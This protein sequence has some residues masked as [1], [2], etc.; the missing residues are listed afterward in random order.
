MERKKF[1]DMCQESSLLKDGMFGIKKDVPDALKVK[2]MQG[3][4]AGNI[5]YYPCGYTLSFIQGKTTHTCILHDLE[6]NSVCNVDL[7][8]VEPIL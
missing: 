1:L 7:S 2:V 3:R 6:C 5:Y 8:F 4:Y